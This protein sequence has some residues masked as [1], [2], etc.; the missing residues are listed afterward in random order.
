MVANLL[1]VVAWDGCSKAISSILL[2]LWQLLA[3]N[4]VSSRRVG[5]LHATD[6]A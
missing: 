2:V 6:M 3:N 4:N 5:V 1:V